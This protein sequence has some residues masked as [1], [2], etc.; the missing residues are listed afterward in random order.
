LPGYVLLARGLIPPAI[1]F[2]RLRC[3]PPA[4]KSIAADA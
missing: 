4:R 1:L 3:S 2:W